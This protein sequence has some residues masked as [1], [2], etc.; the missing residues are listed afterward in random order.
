MEKGEFKAGK[1][2][3]TSK[4]QKFVDE[5]SG[6]FLDSSVLSLINER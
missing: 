2:S 3:K 1:P 5:Y 4:S 6:K